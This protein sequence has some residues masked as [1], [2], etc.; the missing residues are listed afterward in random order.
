[1]GEVV[2]KIVSTFIMILL[3][4]PQALAEERIISLMLTIFKNDTAILNQISLESG[5]L[6]HFPTIDTGYY[7]E[8]LSAKNEVLWK[9]NLGVTFT[10]DV[11]ILPEEPE[12]IE[13][14]PTETESVSLHVRIPFLETGKEVIV[15]HEEKPLLRIDLSEHFCVENGVCEREIGETPTICP[16]D[17]LKKGIGKERIMVKILYL[18]LILMILGLI[19]LLL[20]NI[21]RG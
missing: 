8:I 3:L 9:R 11:I 20:K 13:E 18:I 15:R 21:K 17:C 10:V 2:R 1:M 12:S 14:V 16:R 6:S 4:F 7:I 19:I 5:T